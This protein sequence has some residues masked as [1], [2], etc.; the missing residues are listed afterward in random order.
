MKFRDSACRT[1]ILLFG[2]AISLHLMRDYHRLLSLFTFHSAMCFISLLY[3]VSIYLLPEPEGHLVLCTLG[4]VDIADIYSGARH[5]LQCL[6]PL[7]CNQ[8]ST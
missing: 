4:C 1:G 3:K 2:S 5:L 8:M 6:A 7:A